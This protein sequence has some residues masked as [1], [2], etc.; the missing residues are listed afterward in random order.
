MRFIAVL[1]LKYKQTEN[2]RDAKEVVVVGGAPSGAS[3]C[4]QHDLDSSDQFCLH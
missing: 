3:G 1:T 2:P 4:E